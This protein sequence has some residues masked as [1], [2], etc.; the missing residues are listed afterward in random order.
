MDEEIC[1]AVNRI[2]QNLSPWRD[3]PLLQPSNHVK[4]RDLERLGYRYTEIVSDGLC[5]NREELKE[6]LD[7][8]RTFVVI[9][10]DKLLGSITEE[11]TRS[12]SLRNIA[13]A[14]AAID[15]A[16]AAYESYQ[17]QEEPLIP[18]IISPCNA[19]VNEIKERLGTRK[20]AYYN[21]F[22]DHII[23][24]YSSQG[25]EYPM[26]IVSLVRNNPWR[27]IG[28]LEDEKLRAQVYVACSRAQ[29]KLIV[30]MSRNT[31]GGNLCTRNL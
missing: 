9:N 10:T 26:V 16:I 6:F 8:S 15:I 12:G 13:E 4:D 30:L 7:P 2:R 1:N 3:S 21:I 17:S 20:P 31:F 14:E 5:L 27:R 25:K 19:Q 22:K 11:R 24:A 18:T 29:A 23:T 28:F